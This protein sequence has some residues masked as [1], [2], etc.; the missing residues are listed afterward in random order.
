MIHS[1]LENT[2][3]QLLPIRKPG[4]PIWPEVVKSYKLKKN[5]ETILSKINDPE[6]TQ[7]LK[8]QLRKELDEIIASENQVEIVYPVKVA[9][10]V[11]KHIFIYG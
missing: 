3:F 11:M 1:Y 2:E 5:K 6:I 10:D 9:D 8:T 4:D 7:E